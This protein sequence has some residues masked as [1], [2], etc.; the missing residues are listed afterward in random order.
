MGRHKKPDQ[1]LNSF[2][3]H[4]SGRISF[5]TSVSADSLDC[6]SCWVLVLS[7]RHVLHRHSSQHRRL[8]LPRLFV[9]NPHVPDERNLLSFNCNASNRTN[10]RPHTIPPHQRSRYNPSLNPRQHP[11]LNTVQLSMD[12]NSIPNLF[13]NSNKPHE[14]TTYQMISLQNL[15][16][17]PVF[18]L[19]LHVL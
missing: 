14:K 5:L 2:G 4:N 1:L 3:S 18:M 17:S 8:Q 10:H 7:N 9:H 6:L 12:A 19:C 13:Y 16:I 15:Q 11:N